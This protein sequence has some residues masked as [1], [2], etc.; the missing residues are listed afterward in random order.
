MK[1]KL[2]SLSLALLLAAAPISALAAGL[3]SDIWGT[4]IPSATPTPASGVFSFREKVQWNMSLELVKALENIELVERFN[5]AWS[6]LYPL[7]PVEVSKFT[8]DLVY[9]FYNDQLKMISY[10]FSSAAPDADF[11]YLSGALDSV[12][13]EHQEAGAAQIV[14]FM[15]QIY[16]GHYSAGDLKSCRGWTFGEDTLIYLFY[17]SDTAYTILY[18]NAPAQVSGFVTTGL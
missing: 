4:P 5:G 9:M 12:Y 2:L 7:S 1:R 14:T 17:H 11:L 18:V 3:L 16:P 10:D 6:I 15:D 8:A 13:G